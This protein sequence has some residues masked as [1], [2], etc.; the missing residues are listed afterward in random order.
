[1]ASKVG[2]KKGMPVRSYL[3]DW[4]PSRVKEALRGLPVAHGYEVVVKP[5]M[6][7]REPSLQALCDFAERRI[8]IQVPEPFHAFTMPVYYRAKR[9]PGRRMQFRWLSQRVTFRT[10]R[11]VIRFLYCHEFFHWYLWEVMGRKAAA[12]TAC[13]RFALENFRRHTKVTPPAVIR[14]RS[15]VRDELIAARK[16]RK[17]YGRGTN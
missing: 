6:Y 12:E 16:P 15:R 8:T 2:L 5:L 3:R 11:E 17:P 13:D 10:R 4:P 9:L 1:M 7:R 14:V